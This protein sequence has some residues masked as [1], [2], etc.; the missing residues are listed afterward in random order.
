MHE[1][2]DS[3]L[4]DVR[5]GVRRVR[6]LNIFSRE[7]GLSGK[8]DV[9][10]FRNI[11]GKML[12]FPV[13]YK[14][15]QP[16]SNL[17]DSAQLCAQAL[18]LEEMM[19][20]SIEEGALFYGKIRHRLAVKFDAVLRNETKRVIEAVHR[21]VENRVIP[22]GRYEKKCNT[23]SLNEVCMPRLKEEKIKRYIKEMYKDY[24]EAS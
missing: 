16:K 11:D 15:G 14:S 12:P 4:E 21:M 1:R 20:V 19:K 13:E 22:E 6:S 7:Y 23:C 24:E 3:G 17:S 8:A 2:A 10:E 9:V 18:C 5:D